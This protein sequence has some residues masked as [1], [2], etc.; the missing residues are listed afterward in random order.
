MMVWG[1]RANMVEIAST[2]IDAFSVTST[3]YASPSS[4]PHMHAVSVSYS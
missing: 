2:T 1:V 4:M 3:R